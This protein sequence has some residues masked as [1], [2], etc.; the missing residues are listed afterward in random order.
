MHMNKMPLGEGKAMFITITDAKQPSQKGSNIKHNDAT[1]YYQP[2]KTKECWYPRS[3]KESERPVIG[4]TMSTAPGQLLHTSITFQVIPA[5]LQ[6]AGY[7]RLHYLTVHKI[8]LN[9]GHK[10]TFTK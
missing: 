1:Q 6:G 10:Y 4:S 5:L 3:G 9:V 7:H 8:F 2:L